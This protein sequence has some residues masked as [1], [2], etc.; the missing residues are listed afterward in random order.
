MLRK[1]VHIIFCAILLLPLT[2]VLSLI[3]MDIEPLQYYLSLGVIAAT[4]NSI[5]VKRPL[6]S[7]EIRERMIS[8]RKRILE[9]ILNLRIMKILPLGQKVIEGIDELGDMLE[10]LESSFNEQIRRMERSYE[11]VGG[12]IGVTLGIIGVAFSYAMVRDYTIYGIYALMI[13]DP[14]GAIIG[15]MY[16]RNRIPFS[17]AT[18]EGAAAEFIVFTIFLVFALSIDVYRSILIALIATVAEVFGVEDNLFIP[19]AVSLATYI[20][21]I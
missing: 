3:P 12:Y 6:L 10:K 21:G 1:A 13:M 14:V 16:G 15:I 18:I 4:V 8:A 11:K 7:V 5:Q 17:N 20:L 19:V 2:K 9:E